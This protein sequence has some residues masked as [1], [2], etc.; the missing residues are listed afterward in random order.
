MTHTLLGG[1]MAI[2][3]GAAAPP[4]GLAPPWRRLC[5]G[6]C[7]IEGETATLYAFINVTTVPIIKHIANLFF[8]K[9][10]PFDF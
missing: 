2:L 4:S 9:G 7:L 10:A 1:A 5:L 3:G 8:I 6:A